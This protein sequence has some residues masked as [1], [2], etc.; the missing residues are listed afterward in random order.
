MSF[1]EKYFKYKAKYLA[2]KNNLQN[3]EAGSYENAKKVF[4]EKLVKN[5]DVVLNILNN[6]KFL[7]KQINNDETINF[8]LP[9]AQEINLI[10]EHG[11]Q[12]KTKKKKMTGQIMDEIN[13][14][15][16]E[17]KNDT[18]LSEEEKIELFKKLELE[19]ASAT[20]LL[21][22]QIEQINLNPQEFTL[23]KIFE[24]FKSIIDPSG[25][26]LFIKFYLTEN[27]FGNPNSVE[28]IGRLKD[29][30]NIYDRIKE[31]KKQKKTEELTSDDLTPLSNFS[32]LTNLEKYTDNFKKE[33]EESENK[34]QE[35]RELQKKIKEEG[36]N[37]VVTIMDLERFIIYQPTTENG[38]KYYGRNTRWCT[39]SQN[40]NMFDHYNDQGPLYIVQSKTDPTDKYQ[41]HFE[42]Q[43]YMDKEDESI[44][45]NNL[46][47]HIG[48]SKFDRFFNGN[49]IRK[50]SELAELKTNN[51]VEF[52]SYT[53]NVK[54]IVISG[55]EDLSNLDILLDLPNI[56]FL[57]FNGELND[58]LLRYLEKIINPTN[59]KSIIV[60]G[61]YNKPFKNS[62]SKF[63]NLEVLFLGNMFNQPFGNS[64]SKLR[65]LKKLRIGSFNREINRSFDN[66]INLEELYIGNISDPFNNPF[67]AL[68]KLKKI[69]SVNF[70]KPI[71]SLFQNLTQLQELI[72]PNFNKPLGNSLNTLGN[73][74][75][76]H[77]LNFNQ[78]LGNSLEKLKE[79]TDLYLYSY[80]YKLDNSLDT[81]DKLTKLNLGSYTN[82]LGNS[83]EK[84]VNL[85]ELN[86][87]KFNNSSHVSFK[88]LTKLKILHID[89]FT[90]I[91]VNTLDSLVKLE[92]LTIPKISEKKIKTLLD[93]NKKLKINYTS[94]KPHEEEEEDNYI[95]PRQYDL[96][97]YGLSPSELADW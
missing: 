28:N 69:T 6:D 42:T 78:P 94:Y 66:L 10:I 61:N 73:L 50:I 74:S 8:S 96:S 87:S 32:S 44:Q 36:E 70:D 72:L 48:D 46:L 90:N 26:E 85:N 93:I 21:S 52:V 43:Q 7:K 54:R 22:E 77:L 95:P 91:A 88:T 49:K 62:L 17:I 23:N 59:I 86:L 76:L 12:K 38:A 27:G 19:Q 75:K 97:E 5:Y 37:D 29:A 56:K 64:L 92:E 9:S 31:K 67:S 53:N 65:N 39:A 51:S 41:L 34:K 33:L 20:Q 24:Y 14:K 81:L 60:N 71:E 4:Y 68:V 83:L 80:D 11:G 63:T 79:L 58:S 55:S 45:I 57:I 2:L 30:L 25:I 15:R 82:P 47:T 18:T 13:K 16:R 89:Q 3:L 84:L 1:K 40:N 35:Q